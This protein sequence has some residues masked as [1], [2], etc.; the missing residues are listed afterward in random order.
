MSRSP[1]TAFWLSLLLLLGSM[2]VAIFALTRASVTSER[3]RTRARL[4]NELRSER[5]LANAC[6]A[7]AARL[8]LHPVT[9]DALTALISGQRGT[10]KSHETSRGRENW[11]I[12]RAT[13]TYTAVRPEQLAGLHSCRTLNHPWH[14]ESLNAS[15]DATGRLAATVTYETLSPALP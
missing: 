5:A 15:A 2:G 11:T 6:D 3:I 8:R 7:T 12:H 4:I 14:I 10:I 1:R 13:I 9:P